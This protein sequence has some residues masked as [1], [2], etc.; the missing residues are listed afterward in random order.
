MSLGEHELCFSIIIPVTRF[1]EVIKLLKGIANQRF[2]LSKV[3][4]ILVSH[5]DKV[6]IV[7]G[8]YPF[9]IRLLVSDSMH[10]GIKR[11][12]GCRV[13]RG[14]Y[15]AF[16]DDDCYPLPDWL[17]E[18]LELLKEHKVVCGPSSTDEKGF[19]RRISRLLSNN[20]L[21]A[22]N[23]MHS[24]YKDV[25]VPFYNVGFY[26]VFMHTDIWAMADGCN[27]IANY[28]MDDKELFYLLSLKNIKFMNSP[29]TEVYHRERKFPAEYYGHIIKKH[30]QTGIN[31][32]IYPEIFTKQPVFYFIYGFYFSAPVLFLYPGVL[33]L[34]IAG[35]YALCMAVCMPYMKIDYMIYLAMPPSIILKNIISLVAILCGTVYCLFN[36]KKYRREIDEKRK[37]IKR[38]LNEGKNN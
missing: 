22:G 18:G 27:E 30:F 17:S 26:N 2:D 36:R 20:I 16:L 3:E 11:N 35:Y 29:R 38:V 9:E 33:I 6:N 10:P 34:F 32:C 23:S 28:L 21:G 24:N 5:G 1:D 31:V 8:E 15:Y 25:E 13:A 14:A 37:R 12:I 19:S 4:V 7:S